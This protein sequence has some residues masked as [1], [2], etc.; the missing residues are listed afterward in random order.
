ML[1][2]E[3]EDG[4]HSSVRLPWLSNY[5][6]ALQLFGAEVFLYK[7]SY[8]NVDWYLKKDYPYCS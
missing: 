8:Q 6:F 4:Q 2:V 1:S 3:Y 7:K 5:H